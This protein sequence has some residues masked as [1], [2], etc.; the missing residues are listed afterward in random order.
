MLSLY[1]RSPTHQ[2]PCGDSASSPV[3][4]ISL[5]PAAPTPVLSCDCHVL[6]RMRTELSAGP[7]PRLHSPIDLAAHALLCPAQITPYDCVDCVPSLNAQH[8]RPQYVLE[9]GLTCSNT[10][11]LAPGRLLLVPVAASSTSLAT[12]HSFLLLIP[13]CH[14]SSFV[15]CCSKPR[16]LSLSLSP[17]LSLCLCAAAAHGCDALGVVAVRIANHCHLFPLPIS[18]RPTLEQQ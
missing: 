7:Q 9:T 4:G 17:C 3:T 1:L 18:S 13:R 8:H 6:S 2:L 15:G 16:S 12:L 5:D 11:L 14:S 10:P